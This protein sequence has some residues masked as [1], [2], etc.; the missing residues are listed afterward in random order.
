VELR[1][2]AD[3]PIHP[4]WS[5]LVEILC[6]KFYNITALCEHHCLA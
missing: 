1:S 2:T 4:L 5:I 6:R 3:F